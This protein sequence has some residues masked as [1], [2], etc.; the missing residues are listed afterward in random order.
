MD[1]AGGIAARRRAKGSVAT[2]A[3]DAMTFIRPILLLDIISLYARVEGVGRSSI[4]V[5]V[6]VKALRADSPDE[7]PVTEGLFTFVALD[8][9][10]RPRPVPAE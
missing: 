9:N 4:K 8:D 7:I 1:I 3:I 10:K 2:V 6:E 5:R